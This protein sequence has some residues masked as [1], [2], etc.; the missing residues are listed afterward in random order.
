MTEN[1]ES[2]CSNIIKIYDDLFSKEKN[3]SKYFDKD[4]QFECTSTLFKC[5]NLQDFQ[6]AYTMI[7]S[8]MPDFTK[9]KVSFAMKD[10][11]VFVLYKC[12]GTHTGES[13]NGIAATNKHA[14]WYSSS[15]Y[16]MN[17]GLI[18]NLISIVNEL[19]MYRQL[20][21]DVNKLTKIC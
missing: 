4:F 5:R 19:D 3:V 13:I 11:K 9:T 16:T 6:D 20:G 18:T 2:A 17:N 10:D 21:W 14:E 7:K 12:S 8:I 15:V 1:K